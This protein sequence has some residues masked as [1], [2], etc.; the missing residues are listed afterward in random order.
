M[1]VDYIIHAFATYGYIIIFICAFFGI[2]GIPAPEESLLVIIGMAC[3]HHTMNF[4]QAS[5]VAIAGTVVGMVVGYGLGKYL[6]LP[7]MAR[8]GKFVGF[9]MA[10]WEKVEHKYTKRSRLAIMG[11]FYLPGIRQVSPY[12]A[13]V[14]KLKF[15]FFFFYAVLGAILWVVPY[16]GAGYLIGSKFAIPP[17]YIS[18]IGF[19]LFGLFVLH[20]IIQFIKNKLKGANAK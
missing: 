20:L 3:V 9:T 18:S 7:I 13:G 10:R 19:V 4:M 5:L 8:W 1:S 11:G 6:G 17:V 14:A 16:L 2:I 15:P 12:V